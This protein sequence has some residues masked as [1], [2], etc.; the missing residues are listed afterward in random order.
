MAKKKKTGRPRKVKS[1]IEFLKSKGGVKDP[2]GDLASREPDLQRERGSKKLIQKKT[3]QELDIAREAA[4]EAGYLPVDSSV[5][6]LLDKIDDELKGRRVYSVADIDDFF[7]DDRGEQAPPEAD[8]FPED[9]DISFDV[10]EFE[11]GGSKGSK[12]RKS[13]LLE[14]KPTWMVDNKIHKDARKAVQAARAHFL[15]TGESIPGVKI[16]IA[17]R[18][19]DNRNP[20]HAN[21]KTSDDPDQSL[22]EAWTTLHKAKGAFRQMAEQALQEPIEP[23]SVRKVIRSSAMVKYHS[24]IRAIRE[25]HPRWNYA[26]ARKAYKRKR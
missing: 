24:E 4:A 16:I 25:K 17:W 21:W 6:D 1:L 15:N 2:F 3:G 11:R 23:A 20:L 14:I 7:I 13:E 8:D 10:E 9:E 19:P 26:R 22:H 5:S 12:G 18:N